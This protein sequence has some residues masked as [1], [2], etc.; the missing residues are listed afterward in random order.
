M[1]KLVAVGMGLILCAMFSLPQV[2]AQASKKP[3]SKDAIIRL[4]KGEVSPGR[5][6]AMARE[7][8]IDFQMSPETEKELRAA[9]A[10]EELLTRLRD[11]ASQPSVPTGEPSS[12]A[13]LV[14]GSTPGG[15]QV[16]VDDEFVGKT[17]AEGRLK[18]PNL[19]VG[20]HRIRLSL[21]G[22][23]DREDK[24]N[25]DAGT[26]NYRTDLESSKSSPPAPVV[27]TKAVGEPVKGREP[28]LEGVVYL[29]DSADAPL[30]PLPK[31]TVQVVGGR[32]GLTG[33]K[34]FVQ[35][36][37]SASSLRLKSGRDMEFVVK[38]TNPE[39]FELYP[40]ANK[41][42]NRQ[43]LTSTAKAHP[44][45]GVTL[46]RVPGIK[47]DVTKYGDSSYRFVVRAPEPGEY[48]FLTGWSAFDFAVEA[49]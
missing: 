23:R 48:A 2:Q 34:G 21:D 4:L 30:R 9:G 27:A 35:V 20:E 3:L 29:L 14:I 18:I 8:G 5:V 25:L 1:K 36:P 47:F 46:E 33:G 22:Y 42:D 19:A 13:T 11:L 37:G 44:F 28:E 40:L 45:G 32:K 49:K 16:Y 38:C 10:T 43:A 12:T 31:E 15:A 26:T 7:Q 6:A 17:N 39:S 24:M 41:G